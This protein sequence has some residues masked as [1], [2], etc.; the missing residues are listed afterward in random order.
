MNSEI[1]KIRINNH[2][3]EK[4]LFCGCQWDLTQEEV[5]N[6]MK[7]PRIVSVSMLLLYVSAYLLSASKNSAT[8]I[9]F[10]L[11][12]DTFWHVLNDSKCGMPC[13]RFQAKTALKLIGRMRKVFMTLQIF[14]SREW[15][16]AVVAIVFRPEWWKL[17]MLMIFMMKM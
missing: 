7:F 11:Q 2:E 1:R 3:M 14:R 17:S 5:Q 9:A 16:T 12:N 8:K 10:K 13:D 6:S 4:S 15:F